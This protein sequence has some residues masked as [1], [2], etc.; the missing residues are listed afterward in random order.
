MGWVQFKKSGHRHSV[1]SVVIS[2]LVCCFWSP[3]QTLIAD[4][5]TAADLEFFEKQ[6]RPLLVR[7]CYECHSADEAAGGLLLDS[8]RGVESGGDSGKAAVP[9]KPDHSLLIEAVR[10]QNQDLQMPPDGRLKTE[11][12]A[13]LEEW[14]RRNLPDPRTAGPSESSTPSGMTIDEGRTFWAFQPID[15]PLI[16]VVKLS[17]GESVQNPIDA[18]VLSRLE[19]E[20][21]VPAGPVDRRTLLRRVTYDLVGLPPTEQEIRS[22]LNDDSSDAYDRVVERLLA[23]PQYGVRWGRHWLDVARYADSNGLDENLAFGNAWRYRDYVVNSFN[24]DKPIDQF[25]VEQLAGDLLPDASPETRTAT[26]FLVLGA[27]VLAEPDRDKLVMDTIDEQLDTI[28]KA[29]W[30][31]TI[32]CARCHDHKFDPVRQS[33][34]YALAAI[35][36]STK[37]FGETNTG[38]IKHWNE[39]S[40]AT[41][42]EL[43]HLKTVDAE[44]KAL[45]AIAT[46]FRNK[47]FAELR[48]EAQSKAVDYLVAAARLPQDVSLRDAIEA[49]TDF[50]LHPR[51]LH[52][53]CRHLHYHRDEA[54][55]SEWHRIRSR[56]ESSEEN[57]VAAIRQHYGRLF[58]LASGDSASVSQ[59]AITPFSSEQIQMAKAA[60]QD[61]SGFLAV[62]AKPEFAFQEDDLAEYHRLMEAARLAE[63]RAPDEQAAMAV[64]DGEIQD[65]LPISI[66]GSHRNPGSLVSRGLPEVLQADDGSL[67]FPGD[68]SGRLQLARWMVSDGRALTA[69]VFVNRIWGWHFGAGLVRTTENFGVLGDRPSH[70]Q[71]L[72]W[73][74]DRLIEEGWSTKSLH[75]LIV[76]SRTYRMD[77]VHP[78]FAEAEQRD[79]DH[80]L[81]WKFPLRRLDAEQLRDAILAVSGRL[82]LSL[83]G[84]TVPLRNRQFVFDHTSIDH[85]RYESVRRSL[86]LPVIRNNVYSL[87]QQFDY[88]DPTMPTGTRSSTTVAPQALLLMNSELVMESADRLAEILLKHSETTEERI[89]RAYERCF[90]R[91]PS[92]SEIDRS[93]RFLNAKS[94]T[95]DVSDLEPSDSLLWSMFCQSLFASNEFIYVR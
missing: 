59:P 15:T 33:D 93:L 90:G 21:I 42:E 49:A 75:R 71:L 9:E 16:P 50:Q 1:A 4:E 51:I 39:F 13:V 17:D 20:G 3:A 19:H 34:Y 91:H 32:G 81:L 31:L 43:E 86:Y 12:I 92:V 52:H 80:R 76:K 41:D 36:K 5:P 58:A 69:R 77:S 66:R 6:V 54:I 2:L 47:L 46:A 68:Q 89:C 44:I 28:G 72:D 88:P 79:P 10:Y 95:D 38:A 11:E 35:F 29:F 62:P 8:K 84:K 70:P 67:T 74:A 65:R 94:G 48:Q 85:T 18:F 73:L 45:K 63:S 25:V 30:G 57:P 7:H 27:K 23:S 82:D 26:G 40:F 83:G 78:G 24:D 60:L 55:F 87:F 64:E 22:F 61:R 37:T 14:V 56:D 53:C